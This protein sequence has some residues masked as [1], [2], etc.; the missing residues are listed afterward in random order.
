MIES[1][2]N[3]IPDLV[4]VVDDDPVSADATSVLLE[5][6]GVRAYVL[7]GT[8]HNPAEAVAAV[9]EHGSGAVCDHRLSPH[10]MAQFTGAE[11]TAGLY[12][13]GLPAILT[14]QYGMDTDVSIRRWREYIPVLLSRTELQLEAVADGFRRCIAEIGG[15]FAPDRHARRC[16]VRI[17][18]VTRESDETVVDAVVPIWREAE[19]IRF[20]MSLIDDSLHGLI[21]PGAR[22]VAEVNFGALDGESL[23]FRNFEALP[24]TG[25]DELSGLI[26]S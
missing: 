3:G 11:L 9:R 23:F 22:L 19:A 25:D 20:P 8:F 14:T 17:E 5:D 13:G 10:G 1:T 15:S 18:A 4:V 6:V 26:N 24:E 16:L 7:S 21:T 12:R 2:L